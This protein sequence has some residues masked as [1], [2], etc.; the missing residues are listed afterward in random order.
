MRKERC[1]HALKLFINI[2]GPVLTC[3]E[4]VGNSEGWVCPKLEL[5]YGPMS[6]RCES[7]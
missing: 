3:R 5:V 1:R 7:L 4:K 6:F 2:K